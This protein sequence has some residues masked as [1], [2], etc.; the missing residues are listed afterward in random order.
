M[1]TRE[2]NLVTL[3]RITMLTAVQ[4]IALP[5]AITVGAGKVGMD[6]ETFL[7]KCISN[8]ALGMYVASACRQAI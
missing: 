2:T 6:E 4:A 5:T 8:P 7:A 1:T 3:A